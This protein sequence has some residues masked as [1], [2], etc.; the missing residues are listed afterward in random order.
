M[1]VNMADGLVA[2]TVDV[3]AQKHPDREAEWR[4][5]VRHTGD[6]TTAI[7]AAAADKERT[8]LGQQKQIG[9]AY[10]AGE[11][12]LAQFE[13]LHDRRGVE[14]TNLK[15]KAMESPERSASEQRD[16]DFAQKKLA[17]MDPLMAGA[18]YE[19]AIVDGNWTIINAVDRATAAGFP[20]VP[21]ATRARA[22]E[23]KIQH[24]KFA[25]EI[26]RLEA[27]LEA[28]RIIL[29]SARTALR[30]IADHHHVRPGDPEARYVDPAT[31]ERLTT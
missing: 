8:P 24:S 2:A 5:I 28:D 14:I 27:A 9:E 4:L 17:D 22:A 23:L 16:E 30:E 26:A 3:L 31:G 11:T 21:E 25:P 18:R 19:Q 15:R 29:A 6:A 20:I 1:N 10:D 12:R 13:P 7:K